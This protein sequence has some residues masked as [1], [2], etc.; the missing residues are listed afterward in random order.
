LLKLG[1]ISN[2]RPV[3]RRRPDPL[4]SWPAVAP[5]VGVRTVAMLAVPGTT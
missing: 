5:V 4:R 2:F 1:P 3:R